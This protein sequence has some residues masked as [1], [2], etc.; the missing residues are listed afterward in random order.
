LK[1]LNLTKNRLADLPDEISRLVNLKELWL[2]GNRLSPAAQT[3]IRGLLPHTKID[4]GQQVREEDGG[5]TSSSP[6]GGRP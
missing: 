3:R 5:H 6:S 1:N 4:F 2:D